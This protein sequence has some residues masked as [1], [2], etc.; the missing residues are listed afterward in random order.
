MTLEEKLKLIDQFSKSSSNFDYTLNLK[1]EII[2]YRP[3]EDSWSVIEQ[4]IHC[5]DFEVANFHRYR[6]AIVAPGT[7]VLSFDGSWRTTLNYQAADLTQAINI[8]KAVRYFMTSHFKQIIN[9][10]WTNYI[11]SFNENRS[12]NLEAAMKHWIDHMDFHSELIHRNIK[13]FY[14]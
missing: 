6:W 7:A 12:F 14:A 4:V 11:Y 10:D 5:V 1:K 13:M 8:I 9:E 2:L 3:F